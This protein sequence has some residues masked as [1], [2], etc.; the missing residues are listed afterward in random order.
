M[1]AA[2]TPADFHLQLLRMV[3]ELAD[4]AQ[5]AIIRPVH[6]EQHGWRWLTERL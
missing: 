3:A 1:T 2:H 4:A 6:E 5:P